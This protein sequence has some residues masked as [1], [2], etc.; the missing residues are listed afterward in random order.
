MRTIRT[1]TIS[2]LV[3][4][5]LAG[6]VVGVAAQDEEGPTYPT[7]PATVVSGG[8]VDWG[9]GSWE[10]ETEVM[11]DGV[12]QRQGV[13]FEGA[14]FEMDD[15]RLT[16]DVSYEGIQH[17]RMDGETEVVL[18]ATDWRIEN[19][20][21]SWS[22]S[23]TSYQAME[24]MGDPSLADPL[25]STC[26]YTGAGEYEGRS[27]YLVKEFFAG[28]LPYPIRGLIFEG[29]VPPVPGSLPAE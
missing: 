28:E 25:T 26:L 7:A 15:P 12:R 21:G 6:S 14:R 3:L 1:T 11:V 16:G 5:L 19:D 9:E 20:E 23:C 18:F 27:A 24:P 8:M 17:G 13:R 2:S 4:G 29:D 10:E 22:S